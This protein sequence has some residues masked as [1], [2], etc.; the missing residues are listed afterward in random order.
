M[1][2]KVLNRL[3]L[4][5]KGQMRELNLL[6]DRAI[7]RVVRYVGLCREQEKEIEKLNEE[8]KQLKLKLAKSVKRRRR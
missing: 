6:V 2:V 5:T 4:Y 1:L 8:I 7:D 3:G